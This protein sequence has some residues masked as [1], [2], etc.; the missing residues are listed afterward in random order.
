MKKIVNPTAVL[1]VGMLV[2]LFVGVHVL[3][4]RQL[5]RNA[6]KLLDISMQLEKQGKL[7]QAAAYL[8]RYLDCVPSD[9]ESAAH[10]AILMARKAHTDKERYQAYLRLEEVL[11]EP[12][13]RPDVL[14]PASQIALSLG[15][16][17][18]AITNLETLL[19]VKAKDAYAEALYGQALAADHR[20]AEAAQSFEMAR[21]QD[22]KDLDSYAQRARLLRE[23]LNDREAADKEMELLVRTANSARAYLIAADYHRKYGPPHR[24]VEAIARARELDT[25][26]R[27]PDVLLLSAVVS[28]DRKD[29]EG[30]EEAC[31]LLRRAVESN[32]CDPR[33]Y[34]L[35]AQAENQ[36][37]RLNEAAFWLLQG[38]D[39]PDI[40]E[41][42]HPD[43]LWG[44]AE[45]LLQ[46]GRFDEADAQIVE[47][48]RLNWSRPKLQYLRA[49]VL[50]GQ[51]E[52][53]G[54]SKLLEGTHAE[55]RA[56]PE[57]QEAADLLL[58]ECYGQL[59]DLRRQH[60]AC[61]SAF[62][63]SASNSSQL[64]PAACIGL[65]RCLEAEGRLAK[66]EQYY[67][68]AAPRAPLAQLAVAR[69]M[70]EQL[71]IDFKR[72]AR[73][74]RERWDEVE[75]ALKEA[76]TWPS[77]RGG[78]DV[79][80]LRAEAQAAQGR[81]KEAADLLLRERQKYGKV[82]QYWLGLARLADQEGEPGKALEILQEAQRVVGDSP[83]LRL[84]S[85]AL[86]GRRGALGRR[87]LEKLTQ[88]CLKFPRAQW[89]RMLGGLADAFGQAGD[90]SSCAALWRELAELEPHNLR[91][92]LLLF[93]L[94]LQRGDDAE[95]QIIVQELREIEGP[96][97]L[98]WRYGQARR[99]LSRAWKGDKAGLAEVANLLDTIPSKRRDWARIHVCQ[100]ELDE[101]MGKKSKALA[102]YSKA[103]DL[104]ERSPEVLRHFLELLAQHRLYKEAVSVLEL[105]PP[106]SQS[107]VQRLAADIWRGAGDPKRALELARQAVPP[108]SKDYRDQIWLGWLLW[109]TGCREDGEKHLGRAIELA[110]TAPETWVALIQMLSR[111]GQ[112]DKAKSHMAQAEAKLPKDKRGLVLAQCHEILGQPTHARA[113][114]QSALQDNPGDVPTLRA[115]VGFCLNSGTLAEA[116]PLLDALLQVETL[117]EAEKTWAQTT[118]ALILALS[119]ETSKARKACALVG[120]NEDEPAR[121][122]AEDD[123]DLLRTKAE[124]LVSLGKRRQLKKAIGLLEEAAARPAPSVSHLLRLAELYELAGEH[125][126]A[127]E[128]LLSLVTSAQRDPLYS[129]VLAHYVLRLLKNHEWISASPWLQKLERLRPDDL[130]TLE[131][132]CRWLVL[133][134]KRGDKDKA[135]ALVVARAKARPHEIRPLAALLEE[136]NAYKEAEGLYSCLAEQSQQP[137]AILELAQFYKR[138]G[139]L[140]RAMDVCENALRRVPLTKVAASAL[141]VLSADVVD[142]AQFERVGGWLEQGLRSGDSKTEL[143]ASMALLRNLQGR[144]DQVHYAEA[145]E[146][147]R[148][149]LHHD[150]PHDERHGVVLNNLA[151]ILAVAQ[152]KGAEALELLDQAEKLLG[153]SP[154][155]FDTRALAY[156][157]LGDSRKAIEI[158]EPATEDRP[159]AEGFFHLAQAYR[160]ARN[161]AAQDALKKAQELGLTVSDLH[162]LERSLFQEMLADFAGR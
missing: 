105:L 128:R 110:P 86:W 120:L 92:K 77:S 19:K 147:Y 61:E 119:R 106:E 124:V 69:L 161:N 68:L 155:L 72:E 73:P 53:L 22:P 43:L 111:S 91:V 33:L 4:G 85:A 36:A 127:R 51:G 7:D 116:T 52:W 159:T 75:Q 140:S 133:S 112:K 98:F 150:E 81:F 107:E 142:A 162:P 154:A 101:L 10:Y 57:L 25:D 145:V 45:I 131:L 1:T 80:L 17:R 8:H 35:L 23:H 158:L 20:Y 156:I 90:A 83:G 109:A 3:H 144:F 48:D 82:E 123:V 9:K 30:A 79:L 31:R 42:D 126:K 13:Q 160:L 14:L 28:L 15:L 141:S 152:N 93:D 66:A 153:P 29:K 60:E 130:G 151:W 38:I 125:S 63:V 139:Q 117:D 137:E 103:L 37:G 143:R 58:A 21:K 95:T 6:G 76:E 102:Q 74:H 24:V 129:D 149:I 2:G 88:D 148:Q 40:A 54:A 104:G 132:R 27:N 65:A 100:A 32:K 59:G 87:P 84:A 56:W 55:L 89:P 71:A 138:R 34:V 11:R 39:S 47:L 49:R 50:L 114:Y 121:A 94:A 78:L 16:Y 136:L 26:G 18:N 5:R 12:E 64:D 134:T 135:L 99:L 70:I 97:G 41:K 157:R 122:L 46:T 115:F 118:L 146:L 96:E 113:L 44:L 62:N 108:D 67:R